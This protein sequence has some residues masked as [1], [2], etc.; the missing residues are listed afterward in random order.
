MLGGNLGSL[1]YGDVSVI[2][3]THIEEITK[4]A[5]QPINILRA[6]DFKFD[7]NSLQHVYFSFIRPVREYGETVWD[8]YTKGGKSSIESIQIEAMGIA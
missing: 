2:L 7:R 1:L 3:H 8:N 4:K 5:W 6:F